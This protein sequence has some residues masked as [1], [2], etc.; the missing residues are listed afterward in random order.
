MFAI[1]GLLL[2][3]VPPAVVL[4]SVADKPTQTMFVPDMASGSGLIVTIVVR[5][6]PV[7]MV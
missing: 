6:Q 2:F 3:Q 7:P 5:A 1:V 4:V